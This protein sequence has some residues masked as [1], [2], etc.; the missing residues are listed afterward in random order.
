MESNILKEEDLLEETGQENEDDIEGLENEDFSE[1]VLWATD[2]TTETIIS[3]FKKGKIELE[4]HFQRRDAWN[5]KRK[6]RF[7]ESL[8]LGYPIPQIIFAEKKE[9]KNN[10][11]IIDG[12]QRLLSI[13]QFCESL[14]NDEIK[15]FKLTDLAILKKLD[16]L[17]YKD[18]EDKPE[19]LNYKDSLDNQAIRTVIMKNYP[20]DKFLYS[21]FYRLNTGSLP[22]SPQELRQTL[23]PGKFSDYAEEFSS[24]SLQ[25]K[26]ALRIDSLDPRMRD[27][28]IVVRYFAF[29][30]YIEEYRGNLSVFLDNA[31]GKLNSL[32]KEKEA[33]I[34][35]QGHELNEAIKTIFEIFNDNAFTKFSKDKFTRGFNRPVF[36]IM[37]YYFSNPE[38][39]ESSLKHRDK[40]VEAFEDLC[41]NDSAFLG[42][43]ETWTKDTTRTVKRYTAWGEVLKKILNQNIYIPKIKIASKN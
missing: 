19:Y 13:L 16:G 40:I 31:C 29:K 2:W 30:Y 14:A 5:E 37:S 42:S 41:K 7:I 10:Y 4:T 18:F 3:Q 20:D 1:A 38:I 24:D 22:L 6:S 21:V 35:N 8:I 32:W 15:P 28:E 33:E 9:K 11:L 36:D 43:L 12:K 17:T 39:R 34:R 26:K 23:Q 25:I 27:V